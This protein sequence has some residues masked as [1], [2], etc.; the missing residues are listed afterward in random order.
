MLM[1]LGECSS[2]FKCHHGMLHGLA[3]YAHELMTHTAC[4]N[5]ATVQQPTQPVERDP[6]AG[7]WYVYHPVGGAITMRVKQADRCGARV[8]Q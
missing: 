8:I 5:S 3:P 1:V 2:Y 4:H 7:V 6:V